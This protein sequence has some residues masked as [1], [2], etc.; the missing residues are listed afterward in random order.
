MHFESRGIGPWWMGRSPD[1]KGHTHPG[2]Q[3]ASTSS[4][5][6]KLGATCYNESGKAVAN[7]KGMWSIPAL[8]TGDECDW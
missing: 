3:D 8:G 1:D 5:E 2:A 6:R 7:Q 4:G